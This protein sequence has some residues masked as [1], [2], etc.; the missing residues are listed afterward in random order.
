MILY[1]F[2]LKMNRIADVKTFQA[3]PGYRGKTKAVEP[4]KNTR[5]ER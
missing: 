5:D 1:I 3:V 4:E 2:M